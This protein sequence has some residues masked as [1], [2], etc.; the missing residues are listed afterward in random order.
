MPGLVAPFII[1]KTLLA[2][3]K[4]HGK[5]ELVNL[6]LQVCFFTS[7]ISCRV[8]LVFKQFSLN[9]FMAKVRQFMVHT[10]P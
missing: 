4:T 10:F 5:P 6:C 3:Y 1:I 7:C 8:L 2:D 9:I